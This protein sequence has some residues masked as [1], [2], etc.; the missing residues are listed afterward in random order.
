[1]AAM[2]Q[3]QQQKML[4]KLSPQQIQLMKLLQV[5]TANLDE[6]IKEEIEDNP[7][8]DYGEE[9]EEKDEFD[10][11]EETEFEDKDESTKEEQDTL[12]LSEYLGDDG[13]I[14]D[15]RLRGERYSASEDDNKTI[16]VRVEN[17]FHE[18]LE[19][20]M[21]MLQ[22]SD[23]EEKIAKQVIGSLDEAGY[24]R[25]VPEAIVDDLA[26]AGDPDVN[27]EEVASI[28][29]KVQGFD[30][31]GIGAKDLQ[32]CLLIQLRRKDQDN[33]NIQIA[34]KVLK[35]QFDEF[36]K[37][38]Y[39]KICRSQGISE[40]QLKAVIEEI[41]KL[42]PRPG[43]NYGSVNK[44][45]SYV[46]PDFFIVSNNGDLELSLNSKNAPDLHVSGGYKEMMRAYEESNKDNK[47]QKE[48]VM[49]IK[50]KIDSAKWFIDA[51]KQR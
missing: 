49:F 39:N 25:R 40:Q 32:E 2:R 16:P 19:T 30:P 24:L 9:E 27:P 34:Q 42:N 26:F 1:M 23:T 10:V 50:Q 46:I 43:G 4:Q 3:I 51:I 14:P 8:L 31:P 15:Y 28:I 17:S 29:A 45:E 6:R 5:P 7:A 36:S 38:H 37:K 44:A 12:D 11:Q 48:A 47:Q 21:A 18:Y 33:E 35:E 13:D 41:I 22:L 20:Q